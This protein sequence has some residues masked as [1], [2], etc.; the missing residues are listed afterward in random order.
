MKQ[1][2][3]F[4]RTIDKLSG[5]LHDALQ[6]LVN[7][8]IGDLFPTMA[9]SVIYQDDLVFDGAWGW[10]EPTVSHPIH[11][12]DVLFDLASVTKLFTTTAFLSLLSEGKMPLSTPLVEI[13]PEFGTLAPR[14]IE[15]GQ[16]PHSRERLP[17]PDDLIGQ[18]VNPA[19]VTLFHLLTHTSGLAPWR[20]IFNACGPV[21][22]PPD[23]P[24][25]LTR[26]KR[27]QN[28]L[29][30]IY[31]TPFVGHVGGAIRYSDLGLIL[32]GEAAARLNETPGQLDRA[33]QQRV[34]D[35][36]GLD[37]VLFNP[38]RDHFI[39][40]DRIAPTERDQLWRK[41]LVW[42]EVH[43]ENACGLGGV[44][45]H[46]GLFGTARQVALFGQAW[47][48]NPT[49]SFRIDPELA[50]MARRE[51]VVS[52]NERR[53][54]GW[55]IKSHEGSSAGEMLSAESF[56]HTGF[57]GTSLWIDPQADLVVV[58]L[59]NS[60][61]PTR[62]KEGTYEFRRALHDLLGKEWIG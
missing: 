10:S 58:L 43:D 3:P 25:L 62:L 33:I 41:R 26:E 59:T 16:D 54:L 48:K 5:S 15:G 47:L 34:L 61:Y 38:V 53:G 42:G 52:G 24:A 6:D 45:G 32:L 20:D 36:L 13:I 14:P 22:Q 40:K 35:P 1:P 49:M 31:E 30:A 19:E 55:M 46:A 9:L 7:D 44:A 60:V 51:Q 28:G 23:L 17:T 37:Q 56:G 4:F 18:T 12:T 27:Y 2:A 57:T 39:K 8:H 21:P 29:A 11:S 50:S